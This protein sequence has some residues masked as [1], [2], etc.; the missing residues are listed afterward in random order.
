MDIFSNTP[1]H[2]TKNIYQNDCRF[3]FYSTLKKINC[4]HDLINNYY[5][6]ISILN[7]TQKQ[8]HVWP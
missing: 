2:N 6:S 1:Q 3:M 8:K 5:Y 4:K 7:N